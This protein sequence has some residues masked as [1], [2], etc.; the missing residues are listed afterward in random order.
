MDKEDFEAMKELP[1]WAQSH[2]V[3][4]DREIQNLIDSRS[5]VYFERAMLLSA[6]SKVFSS[7]LD[8]H[9]GKGW[10]DDYRTIV[11]IHFPTGQGTWHIHDTQVPFFNHLKYQVGETHWDGHTTQ[12][13]YERLNRMRDISQA[14]A[15]LATDFA[16]RSVDR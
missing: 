2:I 6:L 8:H 3:S 16:V 14:L 9:K 12:E 15:D 1:M 13:K 5:D 11:C 7:H 10:E 4:Q